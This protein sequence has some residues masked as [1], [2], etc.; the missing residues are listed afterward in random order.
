MRRSIILGITLVFLSLF[1]GLFNLKAE[2]SSFVQ[3]IEGVSIRK[4]TENSHQGL[5]FYGKLDESVKG[6]AHGFYLVYGKT[7]LSELTEKLDSGA[8]PI[9]IN[10][11]E[12]YHIEIPGS[13]E[14]NNFSVVL[15]GIPEDGYFDLISV[16][17]YVVVNGVKV[18]PPEVNKRCVADVA[19]KMAN[20]GEEV[21]DIVRFD[22]IVNTN[23]KKVS[24][25]PNGDVIISSGV[26]ELN[27]LKL[28]REFIK[29]WNYTFNKTLTEL[30]HEEFFNEAKEGSP[31]TDVNNN[32]LSNTNLYKFFNNHRFSN[33]WR[34]LLNYM[35]NE[36]DIYFASLQANA[37]LGNGLGNN[38]FNGAH[39]AYSLVNF[40][41]QSNEKGLY[42]AIDFTD[43]SRYDRVKNYNDG[44]YVDMREYE[45][46]DEGGEFNL[47][48]PL[49]KPGYNFKHYK[50]GGVEYNPN[51]YYQVTN[52]EEKF[53]AIYSPIEYPLSFYDGAMKI[54]ELNR[55]YN[56]EDEISLPVYEKAGYN[57]VGWYDNSNLFGSPIT[58]IE[59]GRTGALNL[60]GKWSEE[61]IEYVYNINYEL[62]GGHF[63]GAYPTQYSMNEETLLPVP[64]RSGYQFAGWYNNSE[65]TGDAITKI[66]IGSVFDKTF[67]AKWTAIGQTDAEKLNDAKT[68]LNIGLQSGDT[69]ASITGNVT[70][71]TTGMH[72]AVI[73]W[74]TSNSGAITTA[75][76]VTRST[77]NDVTVTLTATIKVNLEQE[78]KTF[79]LLVKKIDAATEYTITFNL[80]GGQFVTSGYAN[81]SQLATAFLTDLYAFVNPSEN[82]TTFMHG[83]GNT[84]G[85]DGLWF[86]NETYRGKIYGAN[87]KTGNNNY[88]LSHSNY[89]AKWAPL[90]NFMVNFVK[91]G[92]PDQDFWSSP[93]TGC[94]RMKQYFTNVKPGPAWSDEDMAAMP[95]G[96]SATQIPNEYNADS[97]A[98]TLPTATRSGYEFKGWYETANFSGTPVTSIPAGSSGN[99]V[100]YAKWDQPSSFTI[101]YNL[102]GG[103]FA[104][105]NNKTTLATDFLTDLYNFVS[106]SENLTS[107]MHGVGKT[108]GFD[109]LW[110]SNEEY[111]AKIYAANTKS[112]NNNYF[113]SHAS[114]GP[115]WKPFANFMVNFV[116]VGNPDQD[117]WASPYTGNLRMKQYFT[118]VKPGSAWSDADMAALPTGLSAS[119]YY[120][121]SVNSPTITLPTPTR[122]G[123]TFDGWYTAATGGTKA[124]SIPTGSTGNKVFYARWSTSIITSFEPRFFKTKADFENSP[125]YKKYT[126]YASRVVY[127][128]SFPIPGLERTNIK[129][130]VSNQF[131]PQGLTYAK[132]YFLLA[133]YDKEEKYNSVIYVVDKNGN[134]KTTIILPRADH[135]GGLAFDGANVWVTGYGSTV[136]SFKYSH[137]T[138]AVNS[139][140]EYYVLSSYQKSFTVATT[141]SFLGYYNNMLWVG[142]WDLDNVEYMYGYT[143]GNKTGTPTLTRKHHIQVP[144]RTQ[145]VA[146]TSTGGI[147]LS[148][149]AGRNPTYEKHIAQLRFYKPSWSSPRSDGLI[150]KNNAVKVLSIP[151]MSEGAV[152]V[153]S[154]FYV[155]FESAATYYLSG[156]YWTDRVIAFRVADFF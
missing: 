1:G 123:Y 41:N 130:K 116:K 70:L 133:S 30:N 143:I 156:P 3:N 80:N 75:G 48:A 108:S 25:S 114:Y 16:I 90:A 74:A 83:A 152:T 96:L 23:K 139:G 20:A 154:Y 57:F 61:I 73:T 126:E 131:V 153:G 6:N 32:D 2:N 107:F 49:D 110:Y 104:G 46:Y 81:K 38:L 71:P 40:F 122:S 36:C 56:V 95:T 82:L 67:Y 44:V 53:E 84:S 63:P 58:N 145:G 117:F 132:D 93:Y 26:Y 79:T 37:I 27:I 12:V 43:L 144:S 138:T 125:A 88:F 47:P 66:T 98:I 92:N 7:T 5:R 100:Y 55:T 113:L 86:S 21:A 149:S 13:T 17:P 34:W 150:Y 29:D 106:P 8:N 28:R 62:N 14:E 99:K 87:I 39:L 85:F 137:I 31:D 129:G 45:L 15:V 136:Y 127:D 118:N 9:Y 19:L 68:A 120:E 155:N 103:A 102:N 77:A 101:T 4:K 105:Y 124:T 109:G 72:D 97:P 151:P 91:K 10:G 121:Y 64:V 42:N 111:R 35:V 51:A 94:L 54:N 52:N 112:G 11:K 22:S 140:K 24:M 59:K 78:T 148:I 119:V 76:V 135:V 18:F 142:R 115:K 141:A 33:K 60:Y 69:L 146:F 50:K 89:Q 128:K 147:I 134:F 65:L